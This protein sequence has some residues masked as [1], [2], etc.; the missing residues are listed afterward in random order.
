MS[1]KKPMGEV[2]HISCATFLN[3]IKYVFAK[4]ENHKSIYNFYFVNFYKILNIIII[5]F[6]Q[7]KN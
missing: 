2:N 5:I 7:R 1:T 4:L 6:S 3:E